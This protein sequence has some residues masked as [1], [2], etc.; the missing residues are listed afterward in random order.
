MTPLRTTQLVAQFVTTSL[1]GHATRTDNPH[2]VTA[3]QVGLANVQN[4]GLA[5]VA[6]AQEGVSNTAYMTPFLTKSAIAT[7]VGNAYALHAANVN[8]PH[9]V[10]ATQVGLGNVQNFGL[11]TTAQAQAAAAH[12]VYM[13]P[14]R[15]KEA[16]DALVATSYA[17]HVANVN[18]PHQTTKAQVGLGVV[19]NYGIADAT[20]AVAGVV[21]D[22]YMTPLRVKEAITSQVGTSFTQH[23]GNTNNPHAVTALQVG[24]GNVQNYGVANNAEALEGVSNTTYMTPLRVSQVIAAV[25]GG[26]VNNH[27]NNLNNPHSVTATQVGLGSVQNYAIASKAE[28]VEGIINTLYMTP[29]RVKEAVDALV[30]GAYAAHAA[31]TTNP[32]LV[33]KTQVG[34]GSVQNLALATQV[35][36]QEGV[37]NDAYM[38]P[39]RVKEAIDA[40]IGSAYSAHAANV[41]NPHS[42]TKA[43]VGLGA[44]QNFGLATTVD[45]QAGTAANLYMTPAL[46]K[47]AIDALVGSAYSA[48]ASNVSNPHMVT[49]DQVGLGVVMNYGIATTVAAQSGTVNDAYMT[50][51]RVK[52]AVAAQVGTAFTDH[53]ANK[54]NPHAVTKDQVGLGNVQNFGVATTATATAGAVNDVYM[55]PLRVKEAIDA[56]VVPT[57]T[58]H[59]GRTDNPHSVTKTQVGLSNVSNYAISDEADA[60]LGS[61]N[62]VY[63]T[64]LRTTQLVSE[65]VTTQL[66]GHAT[67]T[68]NP[69]AVTKAQ[70]GLG[71]V[72]NYAVATSEEAIAAAAANKYMTPQRTRESVLALA[73]PLSHA[74]NTNNPHSVTAAQVGALT[75]AQVNTLLTNYIRRTDEWV[76]G[77]SKEAFLAEARSGT[78]A[79]ADMLGNTTLQG[80]LDQTAE[81]AWMYSRDKDTTIDPVANPSRWVLLGTV[82]SLTAG[83][84]NSEAI[85]VSYPDVYWFM[86]GG[87]KQEETDDDN[88]LAQSPA[89]LIH[90]KTG[91]EVAEC[92]FDIT[93]LSGSQNSD[94][95]FC[96]SYSDG[97]MSVW[98]KV[99]CGFNN[100]TL[101]SMSKLANTIMLNDNSIDVEPSGLTYK[102]AAS[103]SGG[104]SGDLSALTQRVT[105]LETIINSITVV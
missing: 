86:A 18:N 36:A 67:R 32:H 10:T 93:R 61:S 94:V 23:A 8:N 42:T 47:D 95:E 66:D 65:F 89:Y 40:L 49:K 98:V 22:V 74:T 100:I 31:S 73:A 68:D 24:L 30:G 35:Q 58:T 97:V 92:A 81:T 71:I 1:D 57:I 45:A 27:A 3:T 105:D 26:L 103:A 39:I 29:L 55:T 79:N 6:L 87:H 62:T 88:A 69:H 5:T 13:T 52:E 44:V 77:V 17:L 20:A 91:S 33:T 64:P 28:A 11:A 104:G 85:A 16:V 101:T 102:A 63:M 15:V 80:I 41:N 60:R 56:L 50:P 48:H 4:F 53:A 46:V 12:D 2:S 54:A 43:Q 9:S 82:E 59:T 72:E 34:L 75:Q 21:N 19:E 38:T 83:N 51:L 78:A 25:G 99:A 96:Y 90:A 37:A 70:V 7:Q 84:T 14:L 76:A